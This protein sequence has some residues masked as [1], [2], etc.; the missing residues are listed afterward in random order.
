MSDL[1]ADIANYLTN[2]EIGVMGEW[3]VV[4]AN[5]CTCGGSPFGHQPG[6]GYEPIGRIAD[7]LA[8][9]SLTGELLT[10]VERLR[11]TLAVVG[12]LLLEHEIVEV[13]RSG[14]RP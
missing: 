6:C 12:E 11:A 10:E 5:D 1:A 3:L 2:K 13:I 4:A 14:G 9:A 7:L 8:S